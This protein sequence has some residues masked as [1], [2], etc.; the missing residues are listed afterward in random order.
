MIASLSCS[1][2]FTSTT[3]VSNGINKLKIK[4]Y[5]PVRKKRISLIPLVDVVFI[6]LLFFM[7]TSSMA[8]E[9]QLPVSYSSQST[10]SL[11]QVVR[12]LVIETDDGV[13]STNGRKISTS[14]PRELAQWIGSDY[15]ATY[16]VDTQPTISTQALVTVL[17][18]LT[19]AGAT[20]LVI[21]E[22]EP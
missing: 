22:D 17:D 18:R 19:Q 16:V 1:R 14:N 2:R 5:F 11:E 3:I 9:K 12:E 13:I 7:L 10:S 8:K 20:N 4:N 21:K 15:E 6:L